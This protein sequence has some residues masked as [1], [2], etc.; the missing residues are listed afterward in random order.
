MILVSIALMIL[1][2]NLTQMY[3]RG[4]ALASDLRV[5]Q[6]SEPERHFGQLARQLFV[7][8]REIADNPADAGG[9][10][11]NVLEQQAYF[12]IYDDL[13]ELDRK[14]QFI[15]TRIQE[16]EI[17]TLYPIFGME[18]LKYYYYRS[19]KRLGLG[20]AEVYSFLSSRDR[21]L[22]S[23]KR[24]EEV[25]SEKKDKVADQPAAT[26]KSQEQVRVATG[27]VAPK[28]NEAPAGAPEAKSPA[29]KPKDSAGSSVEIDA[30]G[31]G[32]DYVNNY[33]C[34]NN[35]QSI[36]EI[37]RRIGMLKSELKLD[38]F[39][40][41]TKDYNFSLAYLSCYE[42]FYFLPN[43]TPRLDELKVRLEKILDPYAFWI[44][45]G[46]YGA[47]GALIF[48]LRMFL[49]PLLPN[50]AAFR[51]IHRVVLGSLAGM[52]LAWFWL[53]DTTVGSQIAS[54]GF[55]LF[56]LAFIFGFSLDVFFA[57][58]DRFVSLSVTAMGKVGADQAKA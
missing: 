6:A 31:G 42:H 8:M 9:T 7:A 29:A 37:G 33:S 32:A 19:L 28:A 47:L 2:A 27:A 48:H 11:N 20:N 54:V 36:D 18:T 55:G 14:L 58:L 1:A 41:L 25:Q 3:N 52:I 45:P 44:L 46:I 40:D 24:F 30:A 12:Q 57:M 26:G 35:D 38:K 23:Y 50:P 15:Q 34:K 17:D 39:A 53:P 49:N 22:E 56:S 21:D 51:I 43:G 16:Y 10:K 13:R 5:L 4:S